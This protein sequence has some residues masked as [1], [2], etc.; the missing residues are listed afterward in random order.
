MEIIE[1]VAEAV[2]KDDTNIK[3]PE[4]GRLP[5][6]ERFYTLQGEG[7]HSGKPAFFIRLAGCD[8][9]CPWCDSK[10]SWSAEKYPVADVEVLA[11][12]VIASGAK[13]VVVTGGEPLLHNLD[14]LCTSLGRTGAEIYL[15][16]SGSA[17]ASGRFDW[18]CLSPKRNKAPLAEMLAVADE[19]KVVIGEA[20]DFGWAE[21]NAAKVR[22]ECR[23]YLQ[24]EWGRMR[25]IMPDI[26]EYAKRHPEWSVSLQTHKFMD[27]P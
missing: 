11:D 18:I 26:V 17:P 14:G 13:A 21:E 7:F 15:E 25:Q 9:G 22:P 24:P 5:V 27:I 8:V 20:D 2:E 23:L 12:D 1:N 3:V 6:V 16:T 10:E 19:L 4:A